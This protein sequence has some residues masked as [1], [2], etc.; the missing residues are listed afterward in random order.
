MSV[1][2]IN[3]TIVKARKQHVC[4]LCGEAII[5][6]EQYERVTCKYD[7]DIY[8]WK[9]HLDCTEIA[10]K[11]NMFDYADD[12]LTED[13]FCEYIKEEWANILW[14]LDN[15]NYESKTHEIPPFKEQLDFVIKHHLKNSDNA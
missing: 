2:I 7:G 12:G 14:K 8:T 3:D 9:T 10:H 4:N 1:E 6:G 15:E 13:D 5:V 11:L